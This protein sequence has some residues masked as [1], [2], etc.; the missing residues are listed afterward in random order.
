MNDIYLVIEDDEP[1]EVIEVAEQGPEGVQGETGATGPQGPTGATG[2]Q[3][4][5]GPQGP[6]GEQG[7]QGIQGET[8]PAGPQ[9]ATG[10]QG[11]QGIQGEVGPQGPQGDTGATGPQGETGPQGPAGSDATVNATNVASVVTGATEETTPVDADQIGMTKTSASGALRRL[12]FANLYAYIKAKLD[13]GITVAGNWIFSSTTRP[14][15]SATGSPQSN[16]LIMLS[17]GDARY[18]SVQIYSLASDLNDDTGIQTVDPNGSI[19][20]TPGLWELSVWIRGTRDSTVGLQMGVTRTSG[21]GLGVAL[22]NQ[23]FYPSNTFNS[24]GFT[25][26]RFEMM[27]NHGVNFVFANMNGTSATARTMD[28]HARAY[29][30]QTSGTDVYKFAAFQVATA[31]T[32]LVA[33]QTYKIATVGTTNFTLVGAA[34]NNVGTSFVATGAGTGTGTAGHVG[35]PGT[36]KAGGRTFL[37]ARKLS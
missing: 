18:G 36:L 25:G 16:S 3:G 9:G 26:L 4:P 32:A 10:P 7:P 19:T 20:I 31:A 12:T 14:V 17:D 1:L 21:S 34:N 8:G 11:P 5:T 29:I 2:A 22:S 27:Q 28:V 23:W 30:N 24:A 13:A 35:T 37:I 33:G 6:Q 15:S